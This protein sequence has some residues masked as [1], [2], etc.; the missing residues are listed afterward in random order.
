MWLLWMAIGAIVIYALLLFVVARVSITPFRTPLFFAPGQMGVPQESVTFAGRDGQ[1]LSAWW[2]PAP[3]AKTVLIL[4]HG[5]MMNKSE[6]AAIAGWAAQKG[7]A[8]LCFDFPAHGRSP[9]KKCGFGVWEAADVDL[10]VKF[11][12]EKQPG[13]RVIVWGSSMG[14]AASALATSRLGA[15][16]DGLVLDSCYGRLSSAVSGWW[17]FI[18]GKWAQRILYPV[19]F[20]SK[21]M[22][23]IDP[24]TVD[25]AQDIERITVPVLLLHG[26]SDTL[27]VPLEAQRNADAGAEIIW[28]PGCNHS[29]A[30]WECPDRYLADLDRW[31]VQHDLTP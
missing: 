26:E 20:L 27:A 15:P 3:E 6:P 19:R 4:A 1:P 12:R 9:G 23:G 7:Y 29:E 10:A 8:T 30:R 24:S 16:I 18:G 5:Y 2:T 11:A 13:A 21:A 31:L 22:T 14:A 17:Y 28:Y 25:I